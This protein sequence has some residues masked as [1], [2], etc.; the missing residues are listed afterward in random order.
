V[1]FVIRV[2]KLRNRYHKNFD[3]K[4]LHRNGWQLSFLSIIKTINSLVYP[5]ADGV[6]NKKNIKWIQYD[7]LEFSKKYED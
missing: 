5:I 4:K 7:V 2:C 6:V 3:S 1:F